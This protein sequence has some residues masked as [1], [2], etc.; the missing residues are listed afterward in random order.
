MTCSPIATGAA[1]CGESLAGAALHRRMGAAAPGGRSAANRGVGPSKVMLR[2]PR[3][4]A[5]F[6]AVH[7]GASIDD[8]AAAGARLEPIPLLIRDG[9]LAAAVLAESTGVIR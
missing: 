4:H 3:C 6:D 7:A 2:C 1:D 9:V 8:D 5:H